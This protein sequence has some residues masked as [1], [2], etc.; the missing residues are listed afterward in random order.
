[1]L[2]SVDVNTIHGLGGVASPGIKATRK[3]IV[4][5]NRPN[6]PAVKRTSFIIGVVVLRIAASS[7]NRDC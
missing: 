4:V 2:L 6:N 5:A 3:V 1:L 7:R